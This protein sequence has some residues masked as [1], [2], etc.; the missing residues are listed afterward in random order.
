VNDSPVM[1][2]HR[3]TVLKDSRHFKTGEVVDCFIQK[4]SDGRLSV[5][6]ANF[7][8]FTKHYEVFG[9]YKDLDDTFEG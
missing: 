1:P 6:D 8:N 4:M 9:S 2:I 7:L 5:T 3:L